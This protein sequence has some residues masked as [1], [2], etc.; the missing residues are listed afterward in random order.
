[1]NFLIT[2][3]SIAIFIAGIWCY[4]LAFQFDN[5]TLQLLTFLGGILLN[6]LACFIPWQLTGTSR[7]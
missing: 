7:K 4:G 3:F 5:P 2:A 6:L 1:M